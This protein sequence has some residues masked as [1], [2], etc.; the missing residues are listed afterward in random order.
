MAWVGVRLV[1][2]EGLPLYENQ[3]W[4]M[5]NSGRIRLRDAD[6]MRVTLEDKGHFTAAIIFDIGVPFQGEAVIPALN[7][8]AE[9]VTRT[10]EAFELLPLDVFN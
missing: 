2:D 10:V 4:F 3:V 9:E 1:D 8:I 5:D 6:N 7:G